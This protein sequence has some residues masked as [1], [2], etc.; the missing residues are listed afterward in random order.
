M[1]FFPVLY[2]SMVQGY[3]DGTT[4]NPDVLCNRHIKFGAL[5]EHVTTAMGM[6]ALATGHYARSSYGSYLENMDDTKGMICYWR[7]CQTPTHACMYVHLKTHSILLLSGLCQPVPSMVLDTDA[8]KIKLK[9][10]LVQ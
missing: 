2:S 9:P 8:S 5:F 10:L 1:T 6:D 7:C 4:P 3:E